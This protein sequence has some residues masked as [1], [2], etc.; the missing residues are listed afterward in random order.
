MSKSAINFMEALSRKKT[1]ESSK[2]RQSSYEKH[3]QRVGSSGSDS[4]GQSHDLSASKPKS[5]SSN[6]NV[7]P[8]KKGSKVMAAVT[9]FDRKAKQAEVET[10]LDPKKIDAEFEAV[11]V[12][13]YSLYPYENF[14]NHF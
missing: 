7:S 9:L 12:R 2:S 14:T 4:S 11:L 1:D 3:G 13:L 10:A 8:R 5:S 6:G